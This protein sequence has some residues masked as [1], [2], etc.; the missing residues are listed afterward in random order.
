MKLYQSLAERYIDDIK[1][2]RLPPGS[3]LPALRRVA[4]QHDISLSTAIKAYQHLEQR[5]WVVAQPQAGFFVAQSSISEQRPDIPSFKSQT[6]DPSACAPVTGYNPNTD[7]FSP[8]GT[9]MLAPELLP[10]QGLQLSIKRAARLAGNSLHFYPEPQGNIALRTALQQHFMRYDFAFLDTDLVI[11]H[12]CLQG[13]RIAVDTV[14]KE[15]D[16]LAVSSPCFSGLLDLLS[17][18]SRKIIEIPSTEEGL[19]LAQLAMHMERKNIVAGLFSTS[20]VNPLGTSLNTAQ[21]QGLAALATKYQVPIIED[22]VYLELGHYKK[23]PLPAK[24]WDKEGYVIWCSS[25]SKTLAA[26]VRMG[27]CLPGRYLDAYAARHKNT[28]YGVNTL[29]Q[30]SVADFI[31]SGQY[32]SHLNKTRLRL[33]QHSYQYQRYLREQLPR[34]A[35]ISQ[36]IGGLVLWVQIPNLDAEAL[37]QKARSEKIDIRSGVNFS[38]QSCYRDYFRI[39]FGWPLWGLGEGGE[40]QETDAFRQLARLCELAIE[41]HENAKIGNS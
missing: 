13:I 7:F 2:G 31:N 40:E 12:G 26:G 24:Y 20:H 19:D 15:G 29:I 27:W 21:K 16:T 39:N 6:S 41:L 3:R 30:V 23:P 34:S 33:Q 17:N 28:S 18:M 25:I 10:T 11:T 9:S 1:A 35:K 8:L 37:A 5:G 32:L 4:S 22:D 36:P 38:T 14:S